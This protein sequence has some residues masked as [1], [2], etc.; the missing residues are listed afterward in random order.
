MKWLRITNPGTFDVAS[1]VN[2]LGASVKFTNDP[3]GLYGSGTKFA[4]AQAVREHL[5]IKIATNGK[6]W[7]LGTTKQEFRGVDFNKVILRSETGQVIKTPMT[8][9]FG[10]EDWNDRWFIFREFYSNALDEGS[11]DIQ[12][13]D[14]V[15]TVQGC[16]SIFLPYHE[17][18]NVYNNMDDYFTKQKHGTMWVDN[19]RIYRRGVY[20]GELKGTKICLHDSVDITESRTVNI[21]SA[22]HHIT[23]R[24]NYCDITID[25]FAELLQSSVDFKNKIDIIIHNNS[26]NAINFDKAMKQVYG[27]RY[28]ICPNSQEICADITYIGMNPVILPDNWNVPKTG[29]QHWSNYEINS[30]YRSL[31]DKEQAIL[32]KVLKKCDWIIAK[33]PSVTFKVFGQAAKTSVQGQAD[34]SD[35]SISI[36]D[37]MFHDENL[38]LNVVIHEFGHIIT[39]C[40][41][42]DRGFTAFFIAKLVE[43]TQ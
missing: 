26:S 1:A 18:A 21:Y 9:D 36:R 20:V 11:K 31:T 16:T 25:L 6:V 28:C 35:N 38:L 23:Y 8:T 7:S 32:D 13:V 39:R 5:P 29:L 43:I 12:V 42:Y 19:G 40:R 30:G 3:I 37:T 27:E 22:Y 15:E 41:D 10:K 17:F 34:L 14:S 24:F 2:M 33:S 4:M